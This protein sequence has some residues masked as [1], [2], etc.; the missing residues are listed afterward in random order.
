MAVLVRI[1]NSQLAAVVQLYA[2]RTLNLQKLQVHRIGQP[3]EY[4]GIQAFAI[5]RF[6]RVIGLECSAF[7]AATQSFALEFGVDAVQ[8]NHHQIGRYAVDR[9]IGGLGR[10]QAAGVNRFVI[11]GDQPVTAA[12]CRA[13]AVHIEMGLQKIADFRHARA[14]RQVGC[15]AAHAAPIGIGLETGTR[16]AP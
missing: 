1:T 10:L 2:A 6:G 7:Q 5:D 4:G 9:Y 11:T 13:Q 16:A 3:R 15:I 8:I 12:F 14:G